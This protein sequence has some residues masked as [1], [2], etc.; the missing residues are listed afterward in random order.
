MGLGFELENISFAVSFEEGIE[1]VGAGGGSNAETAIRGTATASIYKVPRKDWRFHFS[2]LDARHIMAVALGPID[3]AI[4]SYRQAAWPPTASAVKTR[5]APMEEGVLELPSASSR[6]VTSLLRGHELELYRRACFLP[7]HCKDVCAC[8]TPMPFDPK[9][10]DGAFNGQGGGLGD[11]DFA[12]GPNEDDV[13]VTGTPLPRTPMSHYS[14][15]TTPAFLRPP[16]GFRDADSFPPST[17]PTPPASSSVS[18][19]RCCTIS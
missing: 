16:D 3:D 5:F 19:C 1:R 10:G 6:S 4:D 8:C 2:S 17:S 14:R 12:G 13:L 7:T 11:D 15:G 18:C 9:F